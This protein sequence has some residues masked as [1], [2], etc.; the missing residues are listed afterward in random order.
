MG[1]FWK[2]HVINPP[3]VQGQVVSYL[4][5]YG[6]DK[7]DSK[8]SKTSIFGNNKIAVSVPLSAPGRNSR[9]EKH[10]QTSTPD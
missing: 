6:R 2:I 3:E 5:I 10:I 7:D 9:N 1:T 4:L 8:V